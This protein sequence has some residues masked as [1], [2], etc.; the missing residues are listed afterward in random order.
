MAIRS[1]RRRSKRNHKP[2]QYLAVAALAVIVSVVAVLTLIQSQ[3]PSSAAGRSPAF[4]PPP[5]TLD[6]PIA[7]MWGDSYFNGSYPVSVSGTYAYRT[8]NRLGYK[9]LIRGHGGTGFL[10]ERTIEP[11]APNYLAQIDEG[12]M[13][14]QK[15][16]AFVVIQGGLLDQSFEPAEIEAAA[17]AV[18]RKAQ[19]LYP[20]VPVFLLGPPNPYQPES[21]GVRKVESAITSAAAATGVPLIPFTDLMSHDELVSVLAEDGIHPTED[22]HAILTDRLSAKLVELGVPDLS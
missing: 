12:G 11:V 8:A 7:L 4:T 5:V 9:P 21:P 13:T 15:A 17:E 2:W 16:P 18:I 22:G 3:Q 20:G 6:T 14:L 19:E 1:K 10:G